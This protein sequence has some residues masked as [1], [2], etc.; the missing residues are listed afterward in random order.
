MSEEVSSILFGEKITYEARN[1]G[2]SIGFS[3]TFKG[4]ILSCNFSHKSKKIPVDLT[5][6]VTNTLFNILDIEMFT[7]YYSG[8]ISY[9]RL[10]ELLSNY[11]TGI[12]AALACPDLLQETKNYC[13]PSMI[14]ASEIFVNMTCGFSMVM[15]VKVIGDLLILYRKSTGSG[16]IYSTKIAGSGASAIN[17]ILSMIENIP[18][19]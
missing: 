13:F 2:E 18:K 1:T 17:K 9:S 16:E 12:L 14:K 10:L 5:R 15:Y 3:A 6:I 7:S 8:K 4:L 19:N 11:F